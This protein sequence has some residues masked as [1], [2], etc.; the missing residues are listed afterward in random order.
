MLP[1]P[2][3]TPI[4]AFAVNYFKAD[5]AVMVTAS[6]NPAA[7]NG[8]K[9]FLGNGCQI[10]PPTDIEI[11]NLIGQ[12]QS[13]SSIPLGDTWYTSDDDVV[14]VVDELHLPRL[15]RNKKEGTGAA[16]FMTSRR[17]PRRLVEL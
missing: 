1:R 6:H 4:L 16:S 11:S 9:V 14:E 3:P 10:V 13:V 7:D 8:Y 2:L 5:G 15:I 17:A 12:V